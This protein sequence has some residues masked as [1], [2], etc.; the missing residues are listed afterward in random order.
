MEK[1]TASFRPS[2]ERTPASTGYLPSRGPTTSFLSAPGTAA[3]YKP[4]GFPPAYA[5][6]WLSGDQE[7]LQAPMSS[8]SIRSGPPSAGIMAAPYGLNA[9]WESLTLCRN[10]I[11]FPSGD[12]LGK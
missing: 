10:V 8:A 9:P 2:G 5:T 1:L 11:H 12:H 7:R 6:Q 4:R 3:R